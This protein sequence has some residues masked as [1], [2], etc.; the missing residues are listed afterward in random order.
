MTSL[1]SFPLCSLL[2]TVILLAIFQQLI[3]N[4][5]ELIEPRVKFCT[6]PTVIP[7]GPALIFE[8]L[9]IFLVVSLVLANCRNEH[10]KVTMS[11]P[12]P[13]GRIRLFLSHIVVK[14]E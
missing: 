2:V 12:I 4:E 13:L 7:S 9:G 8:Q 3:E 11:W 10:A 14:R 6:F 1:V 5:K